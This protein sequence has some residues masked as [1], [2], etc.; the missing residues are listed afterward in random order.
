M[1]I[2]HYLSI[3]VLLFSSFLFLSGCQITTAPEP[4]NNNISYGEYYLALQQLTEL[5]LVKEVEILQSK[6]AII[7][8][9]LSKNDYDSQIKL[10]LLY[11][12]PKSPIYNSFSAKALLNQM[13]KEGNN[14]AFSDI[15]PNEQALINLLRDQ[16]NQRLL[17]HNRLLVQQQ[18]Q[19]KTALKKQQ[20][21]VDKIA[22]LEQTIAQLK[23]I[24]QTIDKREQ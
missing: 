16:L 11:S 17:M 13:T 14:A 9:Q 10:L 21:F 6:V 22:L 12:F 18:A 2:N 15:S 24:D 3:P 7:P 20:I 23:K 5:E 1:F 19:Q 8:N 4:K